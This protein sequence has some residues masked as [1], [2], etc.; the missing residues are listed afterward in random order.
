[1]IAQ[2]LLASLQPLP[3]YISVLA[4]AGELVL[5]MRSR[6][7]GKLQRLYWLPLLFMF[8]AN[9][10]IGFVFGIVVLLLFL[11][12]SAIQ[13]WTRQTGATWT[14]DQSP[15]SITMP[16]VIAGGAI[17]ASFMTPYGWGAY[18]VF[19]AQATSTANAYFPELQAPRFRAPQDYI[20]MLLIM[21]AF[22]VLGIR[23]SRDPFFLGLLGLCMVLA[24]RSQSDAWLAVLASIAVLASSTPASEDQPA[25]LSR[26]QL[27][28]AV[29]AA[30]I[31]LFTASKLYL[32]RGRE[33]ILAKLSQSY[34]VSAANYIRHGNLPQTLFNPRPWGGF[35]AWYLPEYPVAVDGRV[36]LYGSDFNIQYAKTMNFD[37]H[38][39]TF[40]PLNQAGTLILEKDSLIG[41]A[42]PAV[43]GFKTAYSDDVAVVLLREGSMK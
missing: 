17:L 12:D 2:Y 27:L 9:V 22:L 6:S 23:R 4:L 30:V 7:T 11:T 13:Y 1:L 5:L 37:Q 25:L 38:Y 28:F 21:S 14:D 19:F 8:W 34:P 18:C 43:S 31:V 26:R 36:D 33:A 32:P 16:S 3:V 24:F 15:L 41:Q 20:L 29:I 35:L 39:S 10:D 42:L 40:P